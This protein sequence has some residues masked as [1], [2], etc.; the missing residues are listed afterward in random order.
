MIGSKGGRA[1]LGV[2]CIA[3]LCAGVVSCA[4]KASVPEAGLTQPEARVAPAP[5]PAP[6][7]PSSEASLLAQAQSAL[8]DVHFDY[9]KSN[10][11]P[12][13]RDTLKEDYLVLKGVA[14]VQVQM[15]GH[16]DERGTV[17]YNL[18]LG[19]RRADS[20]KDYLVSLGMKAEQ[21]S[22]ISF[23]EERPADPG[24]DEAAWAKNRRAHIVIQGL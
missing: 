15:E 10:I 13:A 11:R 16:C 8:K 9:D 14:D 20:S 7:R 21:I 1:L 4:K 22:T 18:A 2:I 12:D 19:Q 6:E 17:E 5:A 24:H 3:M 23:G